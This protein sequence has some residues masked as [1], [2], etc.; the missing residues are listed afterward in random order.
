GVPVVAT[1]IP[2]YNEVVENGVQGFLVP[3]EDP[4]ALAD[5]L[6]RVLK[7][8]ALQASMGEAGRR[9]ARQYDWDEIA[10]R[11]VAFYEE[12]RE[13]VRRGVRGV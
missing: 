7:D 9:R 12:V 8:P 13:R 1:D 11:V 2:G 4:E 10:R 3:P 5:A 6:L